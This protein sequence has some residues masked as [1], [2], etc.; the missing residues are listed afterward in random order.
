MLLV[1]C[2]YSG[3]SGEDEGGSF[4]RLDCV[5]DMWCPEY[6]VQN[7]SLTKTGWIEK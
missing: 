5:H 1:T 6:G 7:V 3:E 4:V 2:G